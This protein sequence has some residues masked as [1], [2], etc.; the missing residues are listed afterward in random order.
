[1]TTALATQ[2][3]TNLDDLQRVAKMLAASGYFDAKGETPQAVAQLATKILAGQEMGYGPFASVQ[4]IHVIQGKPVMSANLMAAAVKASARYD[5]RATITDD[6]VT[7]EIF[8]RVGGKL[9][10]LGVSKFTAADA[11]KAGTQ[12]MQ[13]F[14]RNMMFARAMSNAVRWYCPDVFFG[15]TVY[16]P[17]ELDAAVDGD[18]EYIEGVVTQVTAPPAAKGGN[19][20]APTAP[21]PAGPK[22][23][24]QI[25]EGYVAEKAADPVEAPPEVALWESP[26]DA[27][28]WAVG[29]GASE[30]V[31]SARNAFQNIVDANG[32]KFSTRTAQKIYAAFHAERME[33]AK[34]KLAQPAD[35]SDVTAEEGEA[36]FA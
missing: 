17:D 8:E 14:G 33:R 27:Y 34:E 16:T 20:N 35:V 11:Q 24:R 6:A 3:I 23:A 15:N 25:M 7:I 28:D 18:G 22:N 2:T 13:K 32:G 19:G 9:T 29:I 31:H 10:S 4:G 1:M 21:A 30:N 12:N 36:L 26:Q 5:Y